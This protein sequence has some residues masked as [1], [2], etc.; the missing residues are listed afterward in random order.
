MLLPLNKKLLLIMIV[1]V[2]LASPALWWFD[3]CLSK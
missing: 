2:F 1:L 3:Y